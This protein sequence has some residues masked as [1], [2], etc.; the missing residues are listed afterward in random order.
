ME[1][2]VCYRRSRCGPS[3]IGCD[4][5]YF[6]LLSLT[7]NE[8]SRFAC[9]SLS[10]A[11]ASGSLMKFNTCLTYAFTGLPAAITSIL[12]ERGLPVWQLGAFFCHR[13]LFAQTKS[14]NPKT[15]IGN[16]KGL[17]FLLRKWGFRNSRIFSPRSIE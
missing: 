5:R 8:L 16:L 9:S 11:C 1:L 17:R 15:W 14:T 6:A 4:H 10:G 2:L 3:L 13:N 7:V 12:C